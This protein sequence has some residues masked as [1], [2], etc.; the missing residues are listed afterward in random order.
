MHVRI[1]RV[2]TGLPLP[3]YQTTGAA[4]FDVYSRTDLVVEPHTLARIPTN[5]VIETPPGHVLMIAS[6][7]GLPG[8]KGLIIPH[9][10]GIIDSDFCG[11]NDEILFQVYNITAEPVT[12]TRGERLGQGMFVPIQTP[13]WNEVSTMNRENRGGFGSTGS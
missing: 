9:G 3:A 6:R 4:A 12:V 2:D 7:S 10:F 8:K 11:D 1:K 13:S 5:L